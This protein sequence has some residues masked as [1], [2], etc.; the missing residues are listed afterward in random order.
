MLDCYS[1]DVPQKF[2]AAFL[3]FQNNVKKKNILKMLAGYGLK[4]LT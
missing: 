2:S 4:N 3:F 1:P